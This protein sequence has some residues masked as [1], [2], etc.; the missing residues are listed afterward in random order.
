MGLDGRCTLLYVGAKNEHTDVHAVSAEVSSFAE[1]SIYDVLHSW[2]VQ[3]I[4]KTKRKAL[5]WI[6]L[7][8]WIYLKSCKLTISFPLFGLIGS[9]SQK[10]SSFVNLSSPLSSMLSN[11]SRFTQ[12]HLKAASAQLQL[13]DEPKLFQLMDSLPHLLTFIVAQSLPHWYV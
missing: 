11:F 6:S 3:M 1:N 13:L 2:T 7:T 8:G 9:W 4:R 10:F 5:L 12:K